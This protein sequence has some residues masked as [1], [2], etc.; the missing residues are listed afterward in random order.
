[1]VRRDQRVFRPNLADRSTASHPSQMMSNLSSTLSLKPT[2]TNL[3]AAKT[4]AVKSLD[5]IERV[6]VTNPEFSIG[7]AAA[8]DADRGTDP[9]VPG[10]GAMGH[11]A[12]CESVRSVA[13]FNL[14]LLAEVRPLVGWCGC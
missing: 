4:W 7:A 10:Q 3:A 5:T 11:K 6:L 9:T 12:M 1:M 8:Q 14:G 13:L 2:S